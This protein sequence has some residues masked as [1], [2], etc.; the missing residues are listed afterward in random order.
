[1]ANYAFINISKLKSSAALT[2]TYKHNYRIESPANVDQ[3]MSHLND[4]AVKLEEK[5]LVEKERLSGI[6]QDTCV[7]ERRCAGN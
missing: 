2:Q 7:S 4:E 6:L 3:S 5:N 1:M